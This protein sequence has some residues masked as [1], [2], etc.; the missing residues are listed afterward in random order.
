MSEKQ[1]RIV[2]MKGSNFMK[3]NAFDVEFPKDQTAFT[4]GGKNGAGKS[5]FLTAI[6][7]LFGGMDFAPEK[8]VKAGAERAELSG[9][10]EEVATGEQFIARRYITADGRNAF[11]LKSANGY[12]HSS[13]M[14]LLKSM[15][16]EAGV[17]QFSPLK[18]AAGK[19]KERLETLKTLMGIDFTDLDDER[20][21][22]Y[23]ARTLANHAVKEREIKIGDRQPHP[24]LPEEEVTATALQEQLNLATEQNQR[25]AL[26]AQ[27]VERSEEAI[28]AADREIER[29]ELLLAAER[30]RREANVGALAKAQAD[31]EGLKPIDTTDLL[32]QLRGID[33]TNRRIRENQ[34]LAVMQAELAAAKRKSEALTEQIAG[35]DEEKAETLRNVVF[36]VPGMSFGEEDV[37]FND[38]PLSQCS[39]SERLKVSTATTLKMLGDIKFVINEDASLYDEDSRELIRQLFKEAG[40]QIMFEIVGSD[41]TTTLVFEDG[42]VARYNP[43][44]DA[45]LE[46]AAS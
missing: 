35:I 38:I 11:E 14:E 2:S 28:R 24:D 36:P 26:A 31:A 41:D 7:V 12:K 23:D 30:S 22:A 43:I 37:L 21:K 46:G 10:L 6:A 8:P 20:K 42:N 1:F 29:L 17:R 13:P 16:G 25:V 45:E 18:F 27:V 4:V 19:P 40:G 32:E 15:C 39:A 5:S 3:L 9:V 34:E 33:E 44:P